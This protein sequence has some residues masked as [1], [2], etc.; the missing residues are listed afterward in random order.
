MEFWPSVTFTETEQLPELARIAEETGFT[1]ISLSDHLATPQTITSPYPYTA[2]G[3]IWWDPEAHWPD[4]WQAISVMAAVTERVKFVTNVY[5]LPLRDLL[6]A[7]KAVSTAAYFSNNRVILGVGVGWMEEEFRIT[8]QDFH[9]RGRRTDEMLAVMKKLFAGGMVEHHGEFFDFPPMQISPAPTEP[10]PIHIG[11]HSDV[12]LR[13]AARADGWLG[14]GPY[15]PD[16]V[17]PILDRLQ[18]ARKESG[19]DNAPYEIKLGLSTPP[20]MTDYL[21]MQDLGV[22]GIAVAPWGLTGGTGPTIEAKRE[23]MERFAE[24]FIVPLR[25]E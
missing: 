7:A 17:P 12:A 6:T 22:T 23:S 19:T 15:A 25:D 3:N 2:E 14:A 10:V 20:N 9:T 11:G 4:V 16:E 1:G 5:I 21:R 18:Q 24:K 8:G 13:R